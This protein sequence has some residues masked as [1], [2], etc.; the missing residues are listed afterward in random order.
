[1]RDTALAQDCRRNAVAIR[2]RN[3]RR[4]RARPFFLLSPCGAY[5]HGVAVM[6]NNIY[7]DGLLL[8]EIL[9]PCNEKGLAGWNR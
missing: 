8:L 3:A 9:S 6:S 7:V 2:Y 4:A 5:S 1:M